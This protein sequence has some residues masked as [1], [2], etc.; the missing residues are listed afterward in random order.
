MRCAGRGRLRAARAGP[1]RTQNTNQKADRSATA[2]IL[3]ACQKHISVA[4]RGL[5]MLPAAAMQFRQST[6]S[7]APDRNR[8]ALRSSPLHRQC[9]RWLRGE[10]GYSSLRPRID[11]MALA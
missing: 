7:E 6:G 4:A 8:P 5:D 10:H 3:A 2:G 9:R 11:V 1:D